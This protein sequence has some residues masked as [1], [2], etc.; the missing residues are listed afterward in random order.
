MNATMIALNELSLLTILNVSSLLV[1]IAYSIASINRMNG[2]TSH[3]IRTSEIVVACI[4][5]SQVASY[6]CHDMSNIMCGMFSDQNLFLLN[7]SIVL[8]RLADKRSPFSGR[9]VFG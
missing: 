7:A 8:M 1:I 3:Y 9:Q 2:T 4:A 5:F 6:F